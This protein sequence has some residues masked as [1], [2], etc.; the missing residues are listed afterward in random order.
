MESNQIVGTGPVDWAIEL[1]DYRITHERELTYRVGPGHNPVNK[2]HGLQE[3]LLFESMAVVVVYD[4]NGLCGR[5]IKYIA[6]NPKGAAYE[7][8]KT[9]KSRAVHAYCELF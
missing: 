8:D 3:Q 7:K 4:H 2:H 9:N 5:G 6:L 1:R